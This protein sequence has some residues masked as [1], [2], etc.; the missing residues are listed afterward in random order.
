MRLLL[1]QISHRPAEDSAEA[2]ICSQQFTVQAKLSYAD[3]QMFKGLAQGLLLSL[4]R[5][6][7][8]DF[9]S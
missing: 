6:V 4:E 3:R 2:G 8:H 1:Q 5:S 9:R 7:L